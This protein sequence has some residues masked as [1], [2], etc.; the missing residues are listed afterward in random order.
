MQ[1]SSAPT[2]AAVRIRRAR[3]VA[4]R[5]VDARWR[6]SEAAQPIVMSPF[7]GSA[8]GWVGGWM[9]SGVRYGERGLVLVVLALVFVTP[10]P[11]LYIYT[12]T[13]IHTYAHTLK[14]QTHT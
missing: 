3:V 11:R 13:H 7:E 8:A 14:T 4:S 10:F 6:G 1:T 12:H 9:G 2:G 5:V